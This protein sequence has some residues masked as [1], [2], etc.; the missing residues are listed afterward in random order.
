MRRISI[1]LIALVLTLQGMGQQMMPLTTQSDEARQTFKE[2]RDILSLVWITG[3]ADKL[4]HALELDSTFAIAHVYQGLVNVFLWKDPAPEFVKARKYAASATEG[5]QWMIEGWIHFVTR[6]RDSAA[7]AFKK[8]IE[9]HREEDYPKH[10]L[11]DIY[12]IQDRYEEALSTLMPLI[13]REEPY[14]PALNH[15][16]YTYKDLGD[17]D[18]SLVYMQRFIDANPSNANAYHS[19]ADIQLAL[20]FE[21]LAVLNFQKAILADQYF[22]AAALDLGALLTE[23]GEVVLAKEAYGYALEKGMR[24]YGTDFIKE[25]QQ[26]LDNL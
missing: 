25:V 4:N 8:V 13:N 14:I 9:L 20:G 18:S 22:A 6:N 19:M 16:A 1:I 21:Q 12:R 11:G 5:E 10:L 15:I 24:L 7:I 17:M 2:A 26:R 23:T 3:G